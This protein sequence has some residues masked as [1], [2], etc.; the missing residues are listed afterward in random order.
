M[1]IS[2]SKSICWN[3]QDRTGNQVAC[4]H[5][6]V[7]EGRGTAVMCDVF[8]SDALDEMGTE[9]AGVKEAFRAEVERMA[10]SEGAVI[11]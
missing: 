5:A 7:R 3:I 10:G 11:V 4:L 8:D 9:F 6:D 1:I 2:R